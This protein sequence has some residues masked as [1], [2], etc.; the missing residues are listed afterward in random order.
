M[1]WGRSLSPS[2]AVTYISDAFQSEN[3]EREKNCYLK[4][5]NVY[6]IENIKKCKIAEKKLLECV[7]LYAKKKLHA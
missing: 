4:F 6:R 5:K 2:V 1:F 7:C 3:E